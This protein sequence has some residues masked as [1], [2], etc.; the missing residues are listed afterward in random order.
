M[1]DLLFIED[2]EAL[3]TPG[4]VR[5]LLDPACG[6]GGMLS[7]AQDYLRELNPGA[8]LEGYGQELNAET[9]AICRSD[10]MLKGQKA[11]NIRLG[12]SF[13][14]DAFKGQR[15]DYLLANPP[16]GVEWKKVQREVEDE[17]D[18]LGFAGRFGAGL[19]RINDGSFLF[20][21]HMIS[22]LKRPEE[23]GGRLA[24]V[25]NGSPL[26]TG[27]AGSGE[28]EIRR[29]IIENDWL[30]G[31]VALP[32][33]LF[34][35]T[36]ISTYF[37]IVTNRKRPERRGKVQL[38]DARELFVKMR[39]SLGEKRKEISADQ[40]AEITR[41]YGAFEENERVKILPN[42]AF[43]FQRIT[44][45]RPLRLRYEVTDGDAAGDRGV[46]GLDEADRARA[47]GAGRPLARSWSAS[48]RPTGPRS[49]AGSGPLP[50]AIEKAVWDA[51]AVRDPDAPVITDRKGH[52]EPDP[53]LRDN[54]NV[55]LPGPVDRLRRGP[56][57]A[58]RLPAVPRRRRRLPGGGGPARTSPTPGSTTRRPRSATRSR[59]PASSTATSRRG[60]SRR[61]T[62]RSRRSRRRSS[63]CF[64]RLRQQVAA[65]EQAE[66]RSHR[67]SE[68]WRD[69]WA[70]YE[71]MIEGFD[72]HIYI[73]SQ[74]FEV[75]FMNQRFIERTGSYPLGQKCYR[76][77]HDRDEVCPWCVNDRV[78]RGET[79][80][81]EVQSPKDHRWYYVVNTPIRHPDGSMSKMAMIQDVTAHKLTEQALQEAEAKYRGIYENAVIGIFQL[82]PDGRLLSVN[83]ALARMYGYD[84][85]QEMITGI[86]D[87]GHP[88]FVD[89]QQRDDFKRLVAEAGVI[90]G[91]E[92]QVYR[93]DGSKFWI[94]VDARAVRDETGAISYYEGFIQ[95]ITERKQGRG[96]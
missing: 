53:D 94:A 71:A 39:K 24:I 7:V 50:K 81:W 67:S 62:P 6:T 78:F 27:G 60:R 29:W 74:N 35:N 19:P 28:S 75:E 49:P 43:G 22:K 87:L 93:Q 83:P 72:G 37:W 2:D 91:Q 61:S 3:R 84:S 82:T 48:P 86:M 26:F 36:G 23:G 95:D 88:V 66:S 9:Y 11:S 89:P 10:M 85:P 64:A 46:G 51:L 79:V 13:S 54:E 8:R 69:L 57:R 42:E 92:Y 68:A 76:V 12:N 21:Q 63:G 44:V 38:V 58:P 73:C 20:L 45:E 55:P 14:E 25:F 52:P 32:D 18:K 59:S 96:R 34:Y 70:Q 77:L 1:V 40:I 41:L 15:F 80:R 30:E 17:H 31:I 90:R 56:D 33:Q 4:I 47:P 16:F 65:L 5:T